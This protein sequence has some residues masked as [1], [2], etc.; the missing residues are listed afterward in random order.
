[1]SRRSLRRHALTWLV[2]LCAAYLVLAYFAAPELA[3]PM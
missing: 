1:M 2:A 3:S